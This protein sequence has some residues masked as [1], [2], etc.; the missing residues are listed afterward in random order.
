[1]PFQ[2]PTHSAPF[3]FPDVVGLSRDLWEVIAACHGPEDPPG[4]LVRAAGLYQEPLLA[5]VATC[6]EVG[7][8]LG[9]FLAFP[10]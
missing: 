4:A 1:M 2:S 6:Y 3:E 10:I 7:P 5:L 9:V 8:V